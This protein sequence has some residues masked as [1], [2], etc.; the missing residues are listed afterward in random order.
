MVVVVAVVMVRVGGWHRQQ[1]RIKILWK[2]RN[3]VAGV[4]LR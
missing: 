3:E 1:D 2:E 4:V